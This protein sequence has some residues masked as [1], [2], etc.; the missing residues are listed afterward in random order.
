MLT[1]RLYLREFQL[2]EAQMQLA[3]NQKQLCIER[4]KYQI[5]VE[6]MESNTKTKSKLISEKILEVND[7]GLPLSAASLLLTGSIRQL[8]HLSDLPTL[9]LWYL[10]DRS[11]IES[12]LFLVQTNHHKKAEHLRTEWAYY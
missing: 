6:K 12:H 2:K 7:Y 8:G 10:P 5:L 9:N 11:Q 3:D 4:D 1:E